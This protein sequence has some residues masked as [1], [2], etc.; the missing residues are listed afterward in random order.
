METKNRIVIAKAWGGGEM[1]KL[2]FNGINSQFCKLL[3]VVYTTI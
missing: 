3:E 2:L 1:W